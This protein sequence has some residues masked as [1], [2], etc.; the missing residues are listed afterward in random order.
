VLKKC[1]SFVALA[2][3][4]PGAAL[5]VPVSAG[6]AIRFEYHFT[7]PAVITPLLSIGPSLNFSGDLF[8][9]GESYTFSVFDSDETLLGS[10]TIIS[11][12]STAGIGVAT[13]AL[14]EDLRGSIVLQWLAGSVNLNEQALPIVFGNFR[15]ANNDPGVATAESSFEVVAASVPEPATIALFSLGLAGL[16]LRRRRVFP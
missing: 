16:A 10:T 6:D 8:D 15:D 13:G 1:L 5:A 12:V 2:L 3:S 4:V 9:I 11:S 14:T 7:D